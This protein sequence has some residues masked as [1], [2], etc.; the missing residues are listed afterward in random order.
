MSR[1][2]RTR[3]ADDRRNI[4]RFPIEQDVSYKCVRGRKVSTAGSG[5]T[6]EISSGELTFTTEQSLQTRQKVEV[7]VNWPALLDRT[8]PMKLVI[9]GHVVRSATGSASV[10][11][12]HYEF[13]T[14][15]MNPIPEKP[16][17]TRIH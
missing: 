11:I 9:S 16:P 2:N 8:C 12:D 5:K 6:L 17:T 4:H 10:S 15:A 3:Y 13:R 1:P 14:R 7:T